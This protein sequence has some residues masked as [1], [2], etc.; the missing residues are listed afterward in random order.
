MTHD[1][2]AARPDEPADE[3]VELVRRLQDGDKAAWEL[4]YLRHR[5]ALLFLARARLGPA[6]RAHLG[7]E[8]ILQ[9]VVA[10]V[11]SDVRRFEPRGP[12]SLRRWLAACV[13]NKL[14]SKAQRQE[15]RTRVGPAALTDS[16]PDTAGVPDYLDAERWEGL[17]RALSGLEPVQREVVMLRAIEGRSNAEVAAAV[18]RTPDATSKLYN[19]ALARV[20]VRISAWRS[21]R[22]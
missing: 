3:S 16:I 9:S 7:S 11:F 22:A 13:L 17:E 19:R 1:G 2:S 14:R 8:D 21:E 6:L 12:G 10:D 4:A 5:D 18:G 20:G 15:V